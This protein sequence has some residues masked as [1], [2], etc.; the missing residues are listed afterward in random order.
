MFWIRLKQ[1]ASLACKLM[2]KSG[3]NPSRNIFSGTLA[4]S[5]S[6]GG[7][8]SSETCET[9]FS[10]NKFSASSW[11]RGYP[12][13]TN[14]RYLQTFAVSRDKKISVRSSRGMRLE[15]PATAASSSFS[16]T[17]RLNSDPP[18]RHCWMTSL[19]C[20]WGML[21]CSATLAAKYVFPDAG[22]PMNRHRIGRSDRCL[23]NSFATS[24][25]LSST[26]FSATHGKVS[27]SMYL[28][29]WIF[30]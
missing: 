16:F 29:G 3:L 6:S 17:R 11:D 1:A 22:G 14:P 13:S 28:E 23:Q 4:S 12:S 26:P 24:S 27:A 20:R 25:M 30:R 5:S 7:G 8:S 21:K 10:R 15:A 2:T 9:R 18:R 19:I